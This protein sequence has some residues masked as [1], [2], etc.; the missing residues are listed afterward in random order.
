M[1]RK[2]TYR[3]MA[4]VSIVHETS[5]SRDMRNKYWG[6]C[7]N[8][9]LHIHI[10]IERICC[11]VIETSHKGPTV[12]IAK[13]IPHGRSIVSQKILKNSFILTSGNVANWWREEHILIRGVLPFPIE[14][15]AT[16]DVHWNEA[17]C[18]YLSPKC[19]PG[20]TAHEYVG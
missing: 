1:R 18:W 6:R 20:P 12:P 3:R 2:K 9:W 7:W 4:C 15:F 10:S 14:P 8:S 13:K 17:H 16:V 11:V 5:N 19:Y